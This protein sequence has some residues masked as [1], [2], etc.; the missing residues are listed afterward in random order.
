MSHILKSICIFTLLFSGI[1]FSAVPTNITFTILMSDQDKKAVVTELVEKAIQKSNLIT[2]SPKM[3]FSK[4]YIMASQDINDDVNSDG[5][6]FAVAHIN[7]SSAVNLV[8][9]MASEGVLQKDS[10]IRLVGE[11]IEEQGFLKHLNIAHSSS[12]KHQHIEKI[13]NAFV[14][15][16]ALRAKSYNGS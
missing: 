5:W 8:E 6:T 15:D 4:I 12:F 9:T 11:L 10:L 16:F 13:I 2:V 3:A 1:T 14:S 7:N